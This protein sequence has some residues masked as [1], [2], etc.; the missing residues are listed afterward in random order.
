LGRGSGL[1]FGF[2]SFG[3]KQ[4]T[5]WFFCLEKKRNWAFASGPCFG[6]IVLKIKKQNEKKGTVCF[7]ENNCFMVCFELVL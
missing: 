6:N 4:A 5:G 7:E 1:Y 3:T 2:E